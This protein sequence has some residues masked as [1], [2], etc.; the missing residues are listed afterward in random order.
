MGY[1]LAISM[2]GWGK[3]S[4]PTEAASNMIRATRGH[5]IRPLGFFVVRVLT[6]EDIGWA[7]DVIKGFCPTDPAD[8]PWEYAYEGKIEW[9]GK[10]GIPVI[11]RKLEAQ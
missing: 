9:Q 1:Y 8:A 2:A 5:V 3:G 10:N 11:E 4:S 7:W 6:D